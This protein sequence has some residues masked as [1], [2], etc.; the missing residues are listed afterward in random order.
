MRITVIT[1][2]Y[3]CHVIS[4]VAINGNVH[5]RALFL[6]LYGGAVIVDSSAEVICFIYVLLRAD[7]ATD[8]MDAVVCSARRVAKYLAGATVNWAFK[9]VC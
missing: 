5:R 3:Y 7:F 8:E 9:T 1:C 2:N 6:G 4:F